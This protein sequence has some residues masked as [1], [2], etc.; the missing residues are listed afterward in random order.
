MYNGKFRWLQVENWDK[1]RRRG[2]NTNPILV[3]GKH[4]AIIS[5]ELWNI[6]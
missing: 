3:N 1:K 5:D 6:V 2:K 4:K